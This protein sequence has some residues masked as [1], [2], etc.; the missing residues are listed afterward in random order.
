MVT[1][2]LIKSA[3]RLDMD[4]LIAVERELTAKIT[5]RNSFLKWQKNGITKKVCCHAV[6]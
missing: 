6:G 1:L 2:G 4:V 3:M 5:L